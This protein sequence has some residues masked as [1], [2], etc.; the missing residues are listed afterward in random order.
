MEFL[1]KY[2]ISKEA[3]LE[4]KEM[5]NEGIINF[6]IKNPI[7]ISEKC[8]YL[9]QHNYY[10]YPILKSNIKIFLESLTALKG[11]VNKMNEKNYSRKQIQ[12]ILMDEKIYNII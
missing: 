9:K 11:K 6:I 8:E 4:L 10:I 5:Y 2:G 3:I 1:E 7:F 12:M